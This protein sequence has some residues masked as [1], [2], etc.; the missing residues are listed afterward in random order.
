MSVGTPPARAQPRAGFQLQLS[1]EQA[2]WLLI[3]VLALLS[4]LWQLGDHALHHDETLHAY[5]SWRLLSGEGYLHDPLLHGPFLYHINALVFFLFGDN[6]T[7]ARLAAALFGTLLPLSAWLLRRDFGRRTALITAVLLLISPTALYVGRFARHDIFSVVFELVVFA[8]LLRFLSTRQRGWLI[9]AACAYALM[10]ANQETSF[11]YLLIIGLPLLAVGL[12]QLAPRLLPLFGALPL[13]LALLIFVLPGE[14]VV[15]GS[16][17]ALR[18][19]DGTMQ[20]TPGPLFGWAPL[21]TADNSYALRVRMRDDAGG[22]WRGLS[23]Y[24]G[25]IGLFLRHPAIISA[26]LLSGAAL[27]VLIWYL[28]R[29]HAD[30][31]S[32]AQQALAA[33]VPAALVLQAAWNARRAALLPAVVIAATLFT[34][35]FTN[36]LGIISG[37]AGAL[38]YW[39]AQHNVE[40]GGQPLH[41]YVVQL[42]VYEPLIFGGAAAGSLLLLRELR[43]GGA[44]AL[45]NLLLLSWAAGALLIYSWAGEKMPWLTLH[46]SVPLTI[47]TAELTSRAWR[48]TAPLR[49][50]RDQ[51]ADA[52]LVPAA[53]LL[54]GA[55]GYLLVT[56]TVAAG[57]DSG[58]APWLI[59]LFVLLML[60]TLGAA[61]V[62][63][64]G[65]RSGPALVL[66]GLVLLGGLYSVRNSWRLA[67][68]LPDNARELMVYTQTSPDVAR[69]VSRINALAAQRNAE[70]PP[71]IRHDGETVWN[72]YL[73]NM[74]GAQRLNQLSELPA[75]DVVVAL[76]APETLARLGGP[77]DPALDGYV[78]HRMPLR[79]WFPED[80]TYRRA[81]YVIEGLPPT[82]MIDRLLL[83]PLAYQTAADWWNFLLFRRLPAALG[84]S[85]VIVAVRADL[86]AALG[87]GLGADGAA[88][89]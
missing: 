73:R 32:R 79:W 29:P 25:D 34:G 49:R 63:R 55:L 80:Q 68:Q 42:A 24:L 21:E 58:V 44:A 67:Y 19:P 18:N 28:R 53:V 12:Y 70:A 60:A 59:T 35:F 52:W 26:L 33:G 31:R 39:L 47:I 85:D 15:D 41:Y 14:A 3:G 36:W 88:D 5:Y 27:G 86:A 65:N 11:L 57:V 81:G 82:S 64:S 77:T 10:F 75:D 17:S 84:S 46:I 56:V 69:I 40:R 87:L 83:Q 54:I 23:G 2:A 78:L 22:L 38:L 8:A 76:L 37:S 51:R 72:W 43:R 61:A 13:L 16:N 6:D 62:L 71:A 50:R 45:R 30:G 48:R 74:P 1:M 89:R 9:T 66:L 20:F 7:T 4:R